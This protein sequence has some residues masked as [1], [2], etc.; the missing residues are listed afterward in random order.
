MKISRFLPAIAFTA[1]MTTAGCSGTKVDHASLF[2]EMEG[3]RSILLFDDDWSFH[4]GEAEGAH[5]VDFDE[6]QWRRLDLPHDWSI[7]DIPGTESPLDSLAV[8]GIDMGYFRG[9]TGWY[10]KTFNLP[11]GLGTKRFILQFDGVYM[12]ADIWLNGEHLGNHPYGYTSFWFDITDH[13]QFGGENVI[14]VRVRNEGRNSRWYSGSGIYRHVWLILEE[15]VHITPWGTGI[16]TPVIEEDQATVIVTNEIE[17]SS[18]EPAVLVVTT[19][20]ED[21]DG[22]EIVREEQDM[23]IPPSGRV[24]VN[25]ELRV[26]DPLLWSPGS[27][28]L[29][30]AVTEI[31]NTG[32]EL[33]DRVENSF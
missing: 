30:K 13:L 25:Q 24:Q 7:E 3:P 6:A 27:P 14:A 33:F 32:P 12:D 9:G 10:R 11:F 4:P 8:G 20:I 31:R 1:V 18:G 28:V 21:P 19:R 29:Y 5:A 17:N 23:E 22:K 16:T 15:P 2:T 26:A